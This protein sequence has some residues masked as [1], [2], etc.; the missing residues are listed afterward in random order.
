MSISKIKENARVTLTGKWGKGIGILFAYLAFYCVIGLVT[1]LAGEES[2][3]GSLISII[4]AIIEV[5]LIFGITYSFIKLKRNEE[6]RAFDFL[7]LGFSNFGR[8]WK[9]GLREVLKLLLPV[10]GMIISLLFILGVGVYSTA[11]TVVGVS[12]EP[13]I[14][15][16]LFGIALY[17]ASAIWLTVRSLL[18]SLSTYVAYDNPEM[19]SL[20]V[21]NQSAKMMNGNRGKFFLLGLSFAVW[22]LI[23]VALVL[24]GLYVPA[25]ISL[26]A[27]Y[28]WL[29]PYMQVAYVCFY[30]EL[31]GENIN[32]NISN[33]YES[34]N[35]DAIREL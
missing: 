5:P 8:A 19:R 11:S 20:E 7:S 33:D 28:I 15:L 22:Y 2:L 6:V 16:I 21:V 1:G 31:L 24:I 3:L 17:I 27:L 26:F 34:N 18:Y 10:I 12:A 4:T 23:P 13:S 32:N 29:F 25:V 30:D 14:G 9:I 35:E